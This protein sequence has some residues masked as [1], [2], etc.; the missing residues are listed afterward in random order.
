MPKH[1]SSSPA[2]APGDSA[3]ASSVVPL[4]AETLAVE[5]EA[6]P[7]GAL[8]VRIE[9]EQAS[10]AVAADLASEEFRPTVRAVGTPA[11]ERREPYR[12]GEE[13]VIPVYEERLVVERRLFLKEEVRLARVSR[14]EHREGELPVRRERA[15][16][17]RQQPD[18][19]WSAI[20]PG[21]PLAERTPAPPHPD[22]GD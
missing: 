3:G 13:I 12:D 19:S 22:R 1:A 20:D 9:V 6:R 4:F 2:G 15:V 21:A 7:V 17:E 8:R 10:E 11:A 5:T 14:V 16:V 18:G